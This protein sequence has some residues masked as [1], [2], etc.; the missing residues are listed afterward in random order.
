MK[1]PLA[2]VDQ[3]YVLREHIGFVKAR[4]SVREGRE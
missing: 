3:F 4:L 2:F 1:M